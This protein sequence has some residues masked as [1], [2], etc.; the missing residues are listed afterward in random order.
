MDFKEA[1]KQNQEITELINASEKCLDVMNYTEHGLRH[2][3]YVASVTEKILKKL[4]Y[5]DKM[6]ELG[7]IAGYMHDTGNSMNRNCHG[8]ISAVLA[9]NILKEMG[10]PFKDI[11]VV[12]AAIGNHEEET[13]TPVNP[14]SAALIIADKSDAHRTRVTQKYDPNEIH[15]RVNH[16]IKKNV[17]YIN[18]EK[19]TISGRIYMNSTSSVMEYFAIYLSRISMSEKAAKL[20]ECTFKLYINDVLINSPKEIKSAKIL[21]DKGEQSLE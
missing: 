13:G 3:M 10:M 8:H 5:G 16:A 12:T 18:P 1:V 14:V 19:K 17:V 7:F 9:Y 15:D 11:N 6:S 4:G 21:T 20:L 2:A